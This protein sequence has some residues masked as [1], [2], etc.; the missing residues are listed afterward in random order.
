[1]AR[2]LAYLICLPALAL[3]GVSG[4][5]HAQVAV[6]DL[7]VE[8]ET[9]RG[10]GTPQE[11]VPGALVDYVY[12]FENP[13][14]TDN[15][16]VPM[17]RF[18][19]LIALPEGTEL[20][21]RPQ[22]ASPHQT[23]SYVSASHAAVPLS[24]DATNPTVLALEAIA[25]GSPVP[26]PLPSGQSVSDLGLCSDSNLPFASN[27]TGDLNRTSDL[28]REV[29]HLCLFGKGGLWLDNST[30]TVR[31]TLRIRDDNGT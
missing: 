27:E 15:L 29:S 3:G 5:A 23:R 24:F 1:M 12:T 25:A 9:A 7:G 22:V 13:D 4:A 6:P 30:L 16:T 28:S 2:L 26:D 21:L 19:A 17:N 14:T 11:P 31:I 18:E 10:S 8:V 20:Y